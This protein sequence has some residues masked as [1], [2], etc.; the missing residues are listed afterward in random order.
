MSISYASGTTCSIMAF[1]LRS[2]GTKGEEDWLHHF[3]QLYFRPLNSFSI[4]TELPGNKNQNNIHDHLFMLAKSIH[5]CNGKKHARLCSIRSDYR[6][7]KRLPVPWPLYCML[8]PVTG[9]PEGLRGPP[10][11]GVA[12]STPPELQSPLCLLQPFIPCLPLWDVSWGHTTVTEPHVQ[13][14]LV[15]FVSS[16]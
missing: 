12:C 10:V 15:S 11:R 4:D 16:C 7:Q 9:G 13:R 3:L 14:K 1:N 6:A 5:S 8:M 2:F